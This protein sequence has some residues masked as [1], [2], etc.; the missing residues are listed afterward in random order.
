MEWLVW[1]GWWSPT[2]AAIL[3]PD[4]VTDASRDNWREGNNSSS[5]RSTV[6]RRNKQQT[7]YFARWGFTPVACGCPKR[8]LA[9]AVCRCRNV[10]SAVHAR[11]LVVG[12]WLACGMRS[13]RYCQ[14]VSLQ[15]CVAVRRGRQQVGRL[16]DNRLGWCVLAL[17]RV[18]ACRYR[19]IGLKFGVHCATQSACMRC[20]ASGL[21]V[22][23]WQ[24]CSGLLCMFCTGDWSLLCVAAGSGGGIDAR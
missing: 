20:L 6:C 22:E 17:V 19:V 13:L 18:C 1:V 15:P 14:G 4:T 3:K 12:C 24:C 23:G 8:G 5:G 7:C 11:S 10:R 9:G 16:Y 21:R 2:A